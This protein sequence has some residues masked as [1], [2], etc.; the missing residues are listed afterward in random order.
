MSKFIVRQPCPV[1]R[2]LRSPLDDRQLRGRT[3]ARERRYTNTTV[4]RAAIVFISS[5]EN[6]FENT[7]NVSNSRSI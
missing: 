1:R 5:I 6:L 4:I 2:E 3:R 7:L